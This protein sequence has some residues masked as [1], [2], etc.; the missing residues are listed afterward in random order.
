[1][2]Y[3]ESTFA[4]AD[5]SGSARDAGRPDG[6]NALDRTMLDELNAVFRWRDADEA[7]RQ[8]RRPVWT[9]RASTDLPPWPT[10]RT[11]T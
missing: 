8:R 5:T 2:R 6:L 3:E 11:D 7:F 10:E 9:G 1:M 4:W